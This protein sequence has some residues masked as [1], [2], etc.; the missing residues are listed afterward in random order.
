MEVPE[1][2]K[3]FIVDHATAI[4]KFS[5]AMQKF[6]VKK[7][8]YKNLIRGRG[9]EFDS[10]RDFQPDDDASMID[11]MASLRAQK[12]VARKY[13]EERD[14]HVYFVVDVSN[15]MLFGSG[16]KLKAEYAAEFILALSHLILES[17]DRVG[18]VLY[19]HDVV[20]YVE[21]S[22]GKK[23]FFQL[24]EVLSDPKNYGGSYAIQKPLEFILNTVN[25]EYSVFILVSDFIKTRLNAERVL[26]ML[27]HRYETIA[28]M[29]RDPLDEALPDTKHQFVISDPYSE[30]QIIVDPELAGEEYKRVVQENKNKVLDVFKKVNIDV[31]QLNTGTE[32]YMPVASFL[33]GR[34]GNQRV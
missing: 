2:S 17:G 33:R 32:F 7:I 22:Q 27:S 21:P 24:I 18:L 30:R 13:I 4:T 29:V 25:F 28:V 23:H 3:R 5:N 15:S 10:Y 19:N 9:L 16:D 8:L 6:P 34:S 11:W 14:L 12:T 26:G 31:L 1:K 20:S